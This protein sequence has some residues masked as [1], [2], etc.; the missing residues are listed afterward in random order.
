MVGLYIRASPAAAPND[1]LITKQCRSFHRYR[2]PCARTSPLDL[3]ACR[4]QRAH[5]SRQQPTGLGAGMG[6][7]SQDDD[8]GVGGDPQR[9]RC[10]DLAGSWR[11]WRARARQRVDA[12]AVGIE[13]SFG[14]GGRASVVERRCR[15][16]VVCWC[17]GEAE[18]CCWEGDGCGGVVDWLVC[19]WKENTW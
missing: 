18:V 6:Q 3:D 9:G 12:C 19:R 17:E 7:P 14:E 16:G 10:A 2:L 4:P 11:A 15:E 8:A 1:N 13:G 5:V